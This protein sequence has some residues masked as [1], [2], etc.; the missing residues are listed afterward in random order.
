MLCS[1]QMTS[2]NSMLPGMRKSFSNLA[3]S[4][5]YPPD[6]TNSKSQSLIEAYGPATEA[7]LEDWNQACGN[8]RNLVVEITEDSRDS[9]LTI[10]FDTKLRSFAQCLK[11]AAD[12][13]WL[14]AS[15][16]D[17]EGKLK[18]DSK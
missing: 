13:G 1:L 11:A 6:E 2:K 15:G 10:E 16:K 12:D 14:I 9:Y 3:L 18:I 4:A 17:I 7:A 8:F 5:Q